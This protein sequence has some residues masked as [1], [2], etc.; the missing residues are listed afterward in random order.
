V[1]GRWNPRKV[2]IVIS[3]HGISDGQDAERVDFVF[4]SHLYL[5]EMIKRKSIP[6]TKYLHWSLMDNY[7]LAE[8]YSQH[9]GLVTV[10]LEPQ[11][12]TPRKSCEVLARITADTLSSA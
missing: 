9:I 3:E 2:Q 12:R 10:N 5:K 6:V 4:M 7:E 8:G 1:N 11:E